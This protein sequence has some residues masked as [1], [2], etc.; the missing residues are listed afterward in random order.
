MHDFEQLSGNQ[1]GNDCGDS[2]NDSG[3][4]DLE[5]FPLPLSSNSGKNYSNIQMTEN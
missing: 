1:S 2:G 3:D 4:W 5:V